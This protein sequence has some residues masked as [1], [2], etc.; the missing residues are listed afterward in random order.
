MIAIFSALDKLADGVFF[1]EFEELDLF[2]VG[3]TV[4]MT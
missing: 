1:L 4:V 3:L 2:N